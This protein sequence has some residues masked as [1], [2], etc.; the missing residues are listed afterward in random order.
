[1]V[2][3]LLQSI[4]IFFAYFFANP[5]LY[6]GFIL[7][8]FLSIQRIKAERGSFH[9]RVY[10]KIAD[11][12]I[13]FL[14]ALLIGLYLSSVTILLGLVI[15]PNFI[16]V[17][18]CVYVLFALTLQTRLV[19]PS[20]VLGAILILHSLEPFLGTID[21][22][23]LVFEALSTTSVTVIA[24]LLALLV[25]GEG[26][27]IRTNGATYT[28]PRLERSKRG[29]WI[30]LHV[31]KR[32]WIVPVVLFLPEGMVPSFEYWP[33]IQIANVDLQP[34]LIP[35]LIGFKQPI[36]STIPRYRIQS[37]GL[38]VIAV[39]L[40][41][42]LLAVGTYFA[43]MIAFALGLGIIV[44]RELLS[45][46]EKKYDDSQPAFFTKQPKGCVV[47]GVLPDS[48]AEKM[49]LLVGEV[50]I[51]VNGVYVHSETAFYEALQINSAFCKLEVLDFDGEVRFAQTALYD[52]KHHQIGVLLVKDG[53]EL[54][55]SIF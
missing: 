39:G 54:Q 26:I 38:K 30:G 44:A 52:G 23:S 14:P 34:V 55:N 45:I 43:P 37:T 4:G 53:H 19:S 35:F 22:L 50:I 16:I 41:A 31:S 3:D 5:L 21:F 12:T 1:M 6:I 25:I 27:L 51:K 11:F 24:I 36:R 29:K 7:I 46:K 20:Y 42:A 18:V 49:N 15:T 28:S 2:I 17:L 10:G 9:T 13:P 48:P 8:Y 32:L 33:V 40:V 47:V